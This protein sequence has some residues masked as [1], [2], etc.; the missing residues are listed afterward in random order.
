MT[1]EP[2]AW[3]LIPRLYRARLRVVQPHGVH[4]TDLLEPALAPEVIVRFQMVDGRDLPDLPDAQCWPVTSLAA[5]SF[6]GDHV[7][8]TPVEIV[9]AD[10]RIETASHVLM[11]VRTVLDALD[12]DLSD[13]AE[14]RWVPGGPPTPR[15]PFL[16]R[17]LTYPPIFRVKHFAVPLFVNPATREAL[18]ATSLTGL[19]FR[20]P[21]GPL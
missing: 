21:D 19:H 6:F 8:T 3:R 18:E 1:L 4:L 7:E 9:Y 20:E 13:L 11:T 10:G 5:A 2:P 17:D 14:N 12:P 15:T 16:R